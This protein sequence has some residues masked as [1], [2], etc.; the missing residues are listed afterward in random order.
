MMHSTI[1]YHSVDQMQRPQ[2]ETSRPDTPL[3]ERLAETMLT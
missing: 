3:I 1:H 2:P